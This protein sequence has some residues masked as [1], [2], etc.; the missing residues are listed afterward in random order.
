MNLWKLRLQYVITK[1]SDKDDFTDDK[2][3]AVF[4]SSLATLQDKALPMFT[5]MIRYKMLSGKSEEVESLYKQG[6]KQAPAIAQTLKCQYIEWLSVFGN[7]HKTRNTYQELAKM[8][9]YCKEL[10]NTM[11]QIE[12]AE[13]Q[14]NGEAWGAVHELA[15]DQFG[16]KDIDVWLN[17]L[18]FYVQ[19]NKKAPNA[20]QRIASI[21][22]VA[23]LKLP[24]PLFTE[25]NDK[26]KK[27]SVH[28]DTKT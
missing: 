15:C 7:I 13:L 12:M 1:C 22:G 2:V 9:P 20:E 16:D 21:K 24:G 27:M 14:F 19:F 23:A 10:H 6:V 11:S 5:G 17:H 26:W 4:R 3:D 25:F 28:Y 8:K 18:M